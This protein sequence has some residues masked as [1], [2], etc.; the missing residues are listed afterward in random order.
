[1]FETI[2]CSTLGCHSGSPVLSL[3]FY[4]VRKILFCNIYMQHSP[5]SDTSS[6]S[7]IQEIHIIFQ[8]WKV[9]YSTVILRSTA[10]HVTLV[11]FLKTHCDPTMHYPQRIQSYVW[12]YCL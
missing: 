10:L 9:Q 6:H 3:C 8:K 5:C 11:L 7:L 1:M 2:C 4:V 12:L